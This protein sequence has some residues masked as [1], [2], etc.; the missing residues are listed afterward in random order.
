MKTTCDICIIVSQTEGNTLLFTLPETS[1][2]S[3]KPT[4]QPRLSNQPRFLLSIYDE[5]KYTTDLFLIRQLNLPVATIH[6]EANNGIN[7]LDNST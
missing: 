1:L 6:I 5:R 7:K 3:I 2:T 4:L